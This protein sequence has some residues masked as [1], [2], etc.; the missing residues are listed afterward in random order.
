MD[1][2]NQLKSILNKGVSAPAGILIIIL[3]AVIACAGI[4][5]WQYFGI[6]E[7]RE[8]G[9]ET[10][11]WKTY[12]N[13]EYGYELKYPKD[14]TTEEKT[15]EYTDTFRKYHRFDV[16]HSQNITEAEIYGSVAVAIFDYYDNRN[17]DKFFEKEV[18]LL[19][20]GYSDGTIEEITIDGLK[21]LK[22]TV[23]YQ[24]EREKSMQISELFIDREIQRVYKIWIWAIDFDKEVYQEQTKLILS[25]FRFSE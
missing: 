10:A 15:K 2:Q 25:T 7:K 5:A 9:N 17:N 20:R 12:R 1:N 11:D 21:G 18:D 14:W 13:E 24:I 4:L 3:V 6:P 22:A 19:K 16:F 8:T 23:Y